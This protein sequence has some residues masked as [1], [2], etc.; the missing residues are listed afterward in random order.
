MPGPPGAVQPGRGRGA[1]LQ[2]ITSE[3][4]NSMLF[5]HMRVNR[6]FSGKKVYN[7]G[8]TTI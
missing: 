6:F 4:F 2:S 5:T 7:E 3:Y 1:A 8:R